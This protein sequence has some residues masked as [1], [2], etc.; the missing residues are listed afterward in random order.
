MVMRVGLVQCAPVL[1]DVEGNVERCVAYLADAS[2]QGCDLVVFPECALS[3]YMFAS[4]ADA[5]AAAVTVDGDAV[6][7]LVET[8]HR[9]AV[10]CVIGV[11]IHDDD[12]RL[13]NTALLVGPDGLIGR[14]DKTHIP[15]LGADQY[16]TAGQGPYQVHPTAI[17]QIGLQICYDWRFPEVTRSLALE[18]ADVVVMPTCSPASS[19]ELADYVPRTRAVENAVFFVMVN[20]IGPDGSADFL[21]RSQVVNPAGQVLVDAADLQGIVTADIDVAQARDKDREQGAFALAI[22]ADRRPDLYRI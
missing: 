20:R 21:G 17:G 16:V 10:H 8:C 9:L 1:G 12:G 18:G 3:G 2:S 15:P 6:S 19:S 13:W 22:M 11:L 4:L 7:R 14:Y 5:Q